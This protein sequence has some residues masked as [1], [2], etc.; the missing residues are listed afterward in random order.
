MDDHV[1]LIIGDNKFYLSTHEAFDIA[2]ALNGATR[3]KSEWVK[4]SSL[5]T[6]AKPEV[7]VASVTPMPG[8]LQLELETNTNARD[9]K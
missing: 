3:I 5:L 9:T 7:G 6:Y 2:R 4:G 1:I 8:P